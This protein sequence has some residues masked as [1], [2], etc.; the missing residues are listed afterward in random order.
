MEKELSVSKERKIFRRLSGIPRAVVALLLL[1]LLLPI[2]SYAQKK[3]SV[4]LKNVTV[5]Q[6]FKEI[7]SKGDVKVFYSI[8]DLKAEKKITIRMS[9]ATVKEILDEALKSTN[10][11]YTVK[12][13]T[14]VISPKAKVASKGTP[15]SIMTIT[16]RVTDKGK[17]PL[18]GVNVLVKNTT[19]GT[20]TN[21][22]GEYKLTIPGDGSHVLIFMF[23][24]M[25]KQEYAVS[26][27][28]TLNIT[29]E[30]DNIMIEDVV[31]TGIYSRKKE[32]FTGSATTYS[33]EDIKMIGTQ[34]VLQSLK[35]L[36]PAFNIIENNEYGSDPN[37]LPDIEIRGKSS[38]VGMKE[39]FEADPNQ[40]LFI[41]DGFESSLR[42]ISD[43]SVDRVAS[44]T[45]LKDAASTAIYGA[46]AANGVVVVE[47]K[48]PGLGKLRVG[49]N[50]SLEVSMPDLSDYNLMNAREKLLFEKLS[51]RFESTNII[52]QEEN[53]MRYN[54]LK[55]EVDRGVDT[56][57]L[58]EPVRTGVNHRHDLY[59]DGGDDQMRYGLGINYRNTMGVM[60]NSERQVFGGN[61]DLIYRYKQVQFSN[62]FT[63]DYTSTGDPIVPYY[64]YAA[65]NPYYR[66][67]GEDGEINRYL[68]NFKSANITGTETAKPYTVSNPMWN[69]SR[70][71]FIKGT[72]L[73]LRDNFMADWTILE[74]L[75]L[76]ATI[77]LSKSTSEYENF[78]SPEDTRFDA[79]SILEK[80]SYNNS[81]TDNFG[82]EIYGT[83]S[84]GKVFAEKHRLSL[85]GGTNF[86]HTSNTNKSYSAL[87]FPKGD[88][89]RP[90]FANAYPNGSPSYRENVSRSHN[91]Y[92]NGGYSY[93][94]RYLLDFNYRLDGSSVFGVNK[95]YTQTWA[96]GFAWNAHNEAFIKNN[97]PCISNLKLR[98]SVGNPGNQNFGGQQS[99]NTYVFDTWLQNSFGA[100]LIVN[101]YGNPD[102]D[103]QKTL[104]LNAGIDLS[105]FSNRMHVTL[106]VYRKRTD[107]LLASI[108]LPSSTG[109]TTTLTNSGIQI[110]EGINGTINFS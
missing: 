81:R 62:K 79:S 30:E 107:P 26:T 90:S 21:V 91:L 17:L 28:R 78:Y 96:F 73:G 58:S 33:N 42:V 57:W 106:D 108:G 20:S 46:K 59:V 36:D 71:S 69:D 45:I 109:Q 37:R 43:L 55:A 100:G 85:V 70:N 19:L 32:S 66:K 14:I 65:A 9:V 48:K 23:I 35:V 83:I 7:N 29:L 56:Y 89:T 86:Q 102:L 53:M 103:W 67:T 6:L 99:Y 10:L 87:G 16:G 5:D 41:L 74:G 80:G 2:S 15:G 51:G 110:G 101:D 12:D 61:I 4:D 8:D 49:Y 1:C 24:G 39:T 92:F 3:I 31:V 77:S 40:P 18:P 98:V 47:T 34:S 63:M 104:D 27:S 75:K 13:N 105:M 93:D 88:F 76:S 94:N 68:E 54:R 97:V 84:Y 60:K 25:T 11:S 95:V 22:N 64:E 72:S 38:I 50:A 44:I 82:Y 52:T